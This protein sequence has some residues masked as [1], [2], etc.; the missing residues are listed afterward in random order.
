MRQFHEKGAPRGGAVFSVCDAATQLGTCLF[1][2][3]DVTAK[4]RQLHF[5]LAFKSNIVMSA[6]MTQSLWL[7]ARAVIICQL[8]LLTVHFRPV[9]ALIMN[10]HFR[11][12]ALV[13]SKL[14]LHFVNFLFSL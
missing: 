9:F 3:R 4:T 6:S 14:P 1:I 2:F 11:L 12:S 10:T 5:L 7:P 8:L 13:Q